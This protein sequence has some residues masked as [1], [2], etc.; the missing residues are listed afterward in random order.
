MAFTPGWFS[1]G[2]WT[3]SYF[4]KT[5]G[6]VTDSRIDLKVDEGGKDN[7]VWRMTYPLEGVVA[8]E[9]PQ[10]EGAFDENGRVL[11]IVEGKLDDWTDAEWR[12]FISACW[13]T[14]VWSTCTRTGWMSSSI[15]SGE[16]A[17]LGTW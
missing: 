11:D 5:A 17:G 13:I 3:V 14:K 2:S 8:T 12:D 1:G 15:R 10:E 9:R 7:G 6:Q 16:G 4:Y